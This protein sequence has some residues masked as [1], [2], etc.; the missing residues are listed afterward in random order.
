MEGLSVA[1]SG[2]GVLGATLLALL[3]FGLESTHR[4]RGPEG[5]GDQEGRPREMVVSAGVAL[6]FGVGGFLAII[7]WL[8]VLG[9]VARGLVGT[10]TTLQETALLQLSNG[11]GTATGAVLYLKYA[12]RD[13][14]YLDVH[15]PT[16]R[17]VGYGVA[18]LAVIVG[19]F[20]AVN[21]AMAVFG[22]ESAA[23]GTSDTLA[24]AANP[25]AV[26]G[27]F[28][29]TSVL[30]IGPGEELLYRNVVQKSLYGDFSRAAAVVVGSVIFALVHLPAY[31][32][33]TTEQTLLSL[34]VVF[35]LSL[36]LGA[37]YERTENV[38]VPA[39]VHGL[40]NASQFALIAANETDVLTVAVSLPA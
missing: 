37:V 29:I 17:D 27:L 33:G 24:E 23:H 38:L 9:S 28:V 7:L 5:D 10:P 12:D 30:V 22:I 20:L 39:A 25:A 3:V 31:D 4:R 35:T 8:S 19:T 26:A 40:F 2:P 15:R 6:L 13:W 1:L 21:V 14:D 32:T 36:T 18:G 16:T 11:L 34:V